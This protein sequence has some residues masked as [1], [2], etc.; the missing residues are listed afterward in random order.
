MSTE[1][2][3]TDVNGN[4]FYFSDETMMVYHRENGPAIE[5]SDG[6]TCWYR[7]GLLHRENGPAVVFSMGM[8]SWWVDGKPL[9]EAEIADRIK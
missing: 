9:T 2:S 1:Y 5:F 7:N 8:Q 3:K 6:S 4:K